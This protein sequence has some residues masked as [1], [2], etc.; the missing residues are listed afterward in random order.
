MLYICYIY[1]HMY[2]HIYVIYIYYINYAYAFMINVKLVKVAH[3]TQSA[4]ISQKKDE[5]STYVCKKTN[6]VSCRLLPIR[7]WYKSNTPIHKN[8]LSLHKSFPLRISSVNATKSPGYCG[9]GHIYRRNP[10][11][12]IHFFVQS[13]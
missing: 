1:K 10:Q 3:D 8:I 7:Q 11:W 12:K 2:T 9:F 4:Q 5:H 13:I 6:N